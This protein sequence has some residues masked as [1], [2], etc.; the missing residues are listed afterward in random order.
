MLSAA[1][2]L[3]ILAASHQAHGE[4]LSPSAQAGAT[5]TTVYRCPDVDPAQAKQPALRSTEKTTVVERGSA[6]LPWFEPQTAGN[7]A[8]SAKLPAAKIIEPAK[9]PAPMI[10]PAS[11]PDKPVETVNKPVN[12]PVETVNKP[13]ETVNKPV[14]TFQVPKKV[15]PTGAP[16]KPVK[17]VKVPKKIEMASAPEPE[18]TA[19]VKKK[20]TAKKKFAGRKRV[21]KA[22]IATTK[23]PK[24][25]V[26]KKTS[27]VKTAE[28]TPK[29]E[30]KPA[31][32][33]TIVWTKKDMP[34][35]RRIKTWLGF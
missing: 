13:V 15:E 24:V 28:E 33:K 20:G 11:A 17:T 6:D 7:K 16:D 29:I 32:E 22:R 8:D 9:I 3:V 26:A 31:D 27:D 5:V 4:C 21:K 35:G 18:E 30:S 10:E 23:A 1:S 19:K 34:L 12:K 2:S 25:K 14:E